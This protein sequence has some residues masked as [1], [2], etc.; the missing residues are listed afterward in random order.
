MS[1]KT[2]L[3]H[4]ALFDH[5]RV[6]SEAG[7]VQEQPAVDFTDWD[8]FDVAGSDHSGRFGHIDRQ[9]EVPGYVVERASGQDPERTLQLAARGRDRVHGSV[10]A[11]DREHASSALDQFL[12]R[13]FARRGEGF[14]VQRQPLNAHAVPLEGLLDIG[15]QRVGRV[16]T[17]GLV[18][19]H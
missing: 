8:R 19:D 6:Q 17:G 1:P 3:R 2:A 18:D 14:A 4:L 13:R 15:A 9:A 11:C 5:V 12:D 16:R 10:A 7:V